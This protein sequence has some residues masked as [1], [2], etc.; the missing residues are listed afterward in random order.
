M[1]FNNCMQDFMPKQPFMVKI[2]SRYYKK[3][4]N[5]YG[6]S[7]FYGFRPEDGVDRIETYVPDGCVDVVFHYDARMGRAGAS[8]YGAPL[9]PRP[10]D[11]IAGCA[12]FGARFVAWAPCAL[13]DASASELV[14]RVFPLRANRGNA[15][16]IEAIASGGDFAARARA[17]LEYY[18]RN[19]DAHSPALGKKA[20]CGYLLKE[21]F[22]HFGNIRVLRLAEGSGYSLRYITRVFKEEKGIS[23]KNF[24]RI[25]RFQNCINAITRRNAI[26]TGRFDADLLISRLGYSDQSHM[27]RE[28]KEFSNRTPAACLG[29]LVDFN[30]AGRLKI[31]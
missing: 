14:G 26:D 11:L 3:E 2:A 16:L 6:I 7:H 25:V 24:C 13:A 30:Y 8:V 5:D 28:F 1:V 29:E 27:I 15:H 17:F 19:A 4:I 23:I 10:L 20:L 18:L 12:Y 9:K 31:V 22:A 21:I